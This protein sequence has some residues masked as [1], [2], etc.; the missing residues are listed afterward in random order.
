MIKDPSGNEG[1]MMAA[2]G[3]SYITIC[4]VEPS[5]EVL[6]VYDKEKH[7]GN[8]KKNGYPQL[9]FRDNPHSLLIVWDKYV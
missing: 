2:A 3:L 1:I 9:S 5:F 7:G 4:L 6:M 8:I